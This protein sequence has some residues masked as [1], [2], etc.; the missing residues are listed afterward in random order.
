M[1]RPPLKRVEYPYLVATLVAL[2]ALSA[3]VAHAQTR[4]PTRRVAVATRTLARGT[5]ITAD[6]FV[7]RD[8]TV[9]GYVDTTTVGEGWVTRRLIGAGEVLRS[10]AVERPYAVTANQPV[11]LEWQSSNVR[12]TLRGVATR[13]AALGERIP[14]RTDSGR[15]VEATVI[16]P[17]RVRL[18]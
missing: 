10:P 2:I 15:R 17:G 7:M 1:Q 14:V 8:T 5:V 13:N 6:D 3:T 4:E 18:D 9:R 11:E 16:A 12:L